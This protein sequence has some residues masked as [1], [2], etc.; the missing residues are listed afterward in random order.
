MELNPLQ[1][2]VLQ[3]K[4]DHLVDVKHK[5]QDEWN[6]EMNELAKCRSA[7]PAQ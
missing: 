7:Y 1:H 5:L 6:N 2:F 4:V 3:R